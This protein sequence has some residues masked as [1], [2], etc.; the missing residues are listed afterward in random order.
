MILVLTREAEKRGGVAGLISR[1][2]GMQ[3][4]C[5]GTVG[6]IMCRMLCVESAADG[7]SDS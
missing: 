4:G 7:K 1:R 2:A 6:L 5:G 3:A